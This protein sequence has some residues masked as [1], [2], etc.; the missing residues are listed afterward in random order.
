MPLSQ[1]AKRLDIF[2]IVGT[3]DGMKTTT[4]ARI[5]FGGAV[6]LSC[7]MVP[8]WMTRAASSEKPQTDIFVLPPDMTGPYEAISPGAVWLYQQEFGSLFQ[9]TQEGFES[10]LLREV[11]F[12]GG[13]DQTSLLLIVDTKKTLPDQSS[14]TPRNVLGYLSRMVKPDAFSS[15]ILPRGAAAS[16][17]VLDDQHL[18]LQVS[19]S[20]DRVEIGSLIHKAFR[21][22]VQV[23]IADRWFRFR[24][25][26]G[27][28]VLA[29]AL[30]DTIASIGNRGPYKSISSEKGL[31]F[32]SRWIGVTEEGGGNI[33]ST[34]TVPL[35][36]HQRKGR[37]S[38]IRKSGLQPVPADS[39][40]DLPKALKEG[41]VTCGF[42]WKVPEGIP[43]VALPVSGYL[44]LIFNTQRPN[45]LA[46]RRY[47]K[48]KKRK[49]GVPSPSF[50]TVQI[51]CRQSETISRE[52]A[53]EVA[54]QY[55][56]DGVRVAVS[57]VSDS[58]FRTRLAH[59]DYDIVIGV[60]PRSLSSFPYY[61]WHSS[62]PGNI[63]GY[64]NST[65]DKLLDQPLY[66]SELTELTQNLQ[67]NGPWVV[68]EEVTLHLCGSRSA[69]RRLGFP[70]TQ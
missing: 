56:V 19:K 61:W 65:H 69:L 23:S 33:L 59:R 24:R 49:E 57:L 18:L 54:R 25:P 32:D 48:A 20:G 37:I 39:Q 5:L 4:M 14:A 64:R 42:L 60:F 12:P 50:G 43:S 38:W 9:E 26:A 47:Q 41:T 28:P 40:K 21:G 27:N 16:K 29:E 45:A 62:S 44:S 58:D 35:A 7:A 53:L 31:F 51:L 17:A 34:L 10:N 6:I 13:K 63:S 1:K 30:R 70:A 46:L 52:K 15:L 68:F 11:P 67:E 8:F 66:S 36:S 2:W 22:V 3:L 55:E